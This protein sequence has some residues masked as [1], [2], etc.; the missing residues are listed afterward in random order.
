MKASSP[1]RSVFHS[2]SVQNTR[3]ASGKSAAATTVAAAAV[4]PASSAAR[5]R[6]V[7]SR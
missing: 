1:T 2:A 4:P 3:D 7:T 6:P 5:H